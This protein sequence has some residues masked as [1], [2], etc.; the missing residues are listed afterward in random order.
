MKETNE[1][2]RVGQSGRQTSKQADINIILWRSILT[3]PLM[4]HTYACARARTHTRTHARTHAHTH[5]HT[6]T[7]THRERE[8][9]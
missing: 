9:E 7:H 1:W 8:R 3:D 4:E 5:T 2:R 6:H